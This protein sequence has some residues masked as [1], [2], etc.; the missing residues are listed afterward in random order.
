MEYKNMEK[1]FLGIISGTFPDEPVRATH[2]IL[3]F[4]YLAQYPSHSTVTLA[5]MQDALNRFHTHKH[6]FIDEGV[7]DHFAIQKI[8][9]IEHYVSS[10]HSLNTADAYNTELPERL[11]IDFAKVTVPATAAISSSK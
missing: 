5:H 7:R 10:I 4:I 9:A 2:A 3:D 1:V 11:H 8:H 6:G